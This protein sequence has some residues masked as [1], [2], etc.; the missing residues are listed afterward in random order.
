ML[1][2]KEDKPSGFQSLSYLRA[3]HVDRPPLAG[4]SLL[5]GVRRSSAHRRSNVW[6]CSE[7]L[8][9]MEETEALMISCE[10]RNNEFTQYVR[11]HVHQKNVTTFATSFVLHYWW[12]NNNSSSLLRLK[13]IS[14]RCTDN[15]KRKASVYNTTRTSARNWNLLLD[16]LHAPVCG[17]RLSCLCWTLSKLEAC[18]SLQCRGMAT[19][20]WLYYTEVLLYLF[21]ARTRL[22][23]SI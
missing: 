7:T 23:S 8:R 1:Q 12:Y 13:R 2:K 5:W 3:S 18:W 14:F 17:V 22:E 4:G 16:W 15:N 20:N 11:H 21:P 6:T 9:W 19:V 10:S